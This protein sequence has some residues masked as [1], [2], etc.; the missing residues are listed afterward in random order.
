MS[1]K[2]DLFSK[3]ISAPK[4]QDKFYVQLPG[5]SKSLLR[6]SSTSLP[7]SNRAEG[8]IWFLG[9]PLYLPT[10]KQVEGEWSCVIEEDIA[11]SS[12]ALISALE[13]RVG[14]FNSYKIDSLNIFV[15]DQVTG[16]IPQL[17]VT[18]KYVW[19]KRIDPV[20]LDWSKP[21]QRVQYKLTF[22]YSVLKRWY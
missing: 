15:T 6:V 21:D 4:T 22:K 20:T 2:A 19:L 7:Y 18:L 14:T 13:R 12:G 16:L 9:R 10:V 17:A 8:V 3:A 11:L 5:S 1:L